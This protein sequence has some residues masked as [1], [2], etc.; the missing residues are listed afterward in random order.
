MDK[1]VSYKIAK[2]AKKKGFD[3]PCHAVFEVN[4]FYDPP[5]ILELGTET[6]WNLQNMKQ[7]VEFMERTGRIEF[8]NRE[9]KNSNLNQFLLARP[10]YQALI[11]WLR[12]KYFIHIYS[13]Y[14]CSANEVIDFCY[15]IDFMMGKFT[16]PDIRIDEVDFDTE[17]TF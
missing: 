3:E 5:Q 13:K 12:E 7:A 9:T 10:T 17:K 14:V 8:F 4:K 6:A 1:L 16:H 11:D 15:I 2:L